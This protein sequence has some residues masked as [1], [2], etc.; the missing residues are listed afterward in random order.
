[1]FHIAVLTTVFNR[2]EKT[3]RCLESLF[4]SIEKVKDC[5]FDIYLTDDKSTDG[6]P[7]A[8]TEKFPSINILPGTGDLYWN[9]GM[10]LA[11]EHA[12]RI[13]NYDFFIWLN[14]DSIL[15]EDS[16]SSLINSS[17]LTNRSA[18][19][20][21]AFK[22]E[23]E[24]TPTYG[25]IVDDC[26][27]V[28]N[29]KLQEF[30]LLNGNLVIIP[31]LIYKKIGNLDSVFHHGMGDHDY[32][33]RA[34]KSGFKLYLSPDYVGYCERH[35]I[36]KLKCYDNSYSIV[37]RLKF[38]NS[39]LGPNPN[40]NYKFFWRHSSILKTINFL[41]TTYLITA[42]PFLLGIKS[43]C[44]NLIAQ[45]KKKADSLLSRFVII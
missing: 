15:F 13:K 31:Q 35:D 19:I 24:N 44:I 43:R 18:I 32:G 40:V 38:L 34:K 5:T 10:I 28:P 3:I 12:S 14:D 29:G 9:R 1:M 6:T 26:F 8:I 30:D 36:K 2:K 45:F 23:F 4:R 41:F 20:S 22:S 42:F 16:I 17:Q 25:G 33:L 7:D 37:K 39:P 21:G 11:W 27:L